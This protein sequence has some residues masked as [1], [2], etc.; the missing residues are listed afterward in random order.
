MLMTI[1]AGGG[2]TEYDDN[3]AIMEAM[4]GSLTSSSPSPPSSPHPLLLLFLLHL[5]LL[6][7][8]LT[9]AFNCRMAWGMTFVSNNTLWAAQVPSGISHA[10]APRPLLCQR[11][12]ARCQRVRPPGSAEPLFDRLIAPTPD[13]L[14][15][16]TAGESAAPIY[17]KSQQTKPFVWV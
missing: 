9:F 6:L 1:R 10:E 3:D 8:R 5:P 16:N 4:V 14:P 11:G 17:H 2:G 7:I 12:S 13:Y 15:A